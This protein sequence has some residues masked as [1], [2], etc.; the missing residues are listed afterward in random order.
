MKSIILLAPPAAGKGTQSELLCKKYGFVH[1]STGDLIREAVSKNDEM[2]AYLTEQ[3][4]SGKLVS[5]E[6]ILKLLDTKL[7]EISNEVGVI[8][9]GFPRNLE[10]VAK[11]K[12]YKYLNA[13]V[14]E[15]TCVIYLSVKYDLAIKRIVGRISCPKCGHVYNDMI[16]ENQ[17]TVKGI[18]NDC[19]TALTKRSDDNEDTFKVRYE[20]YLEQTE[21]LIAYYKEKGVLYEVDSSLPTAQVFEQIESIVDHL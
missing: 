18:C 17:P 4:Q 19:Q 13:A 1:I 3:M 8:L 2:S 11:S 20:T 10:Q 5:D 9:D 6:I 12:Q 16:E 14:E 15:D 7:A 21:P